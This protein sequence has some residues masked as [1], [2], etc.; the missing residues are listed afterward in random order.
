MQ[1]EKSEKYLDKYLHSM[2][3]TIG[4]SFVIG[5]RLKRKAKIS[6]WTISL[7]SLFVIIIG[8]LPLIFSLS[9]FQNKLLLA[10]SIFLSIFILILNNSEA[11]N[12]YERRSENFLIRARSLQKIYYN[13]EYL[14]NFDKINEYEFN[15]IKTEYN[16]IIKMFP[17]DPSKLDF[18]F[19]RTQN[20]RKFHS[21]KEKSKAELISEKIKYSCLYFTNLYLVPTLMLLIPIILVFIIIFNK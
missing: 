19:Y 4:V 5:N 20:H 15:R 14:I 9:D 17:E 21:S 11:G 16:D 8:I 1:I 10:V 3:I 6:N 18:Q 7:L 12:N 2:L 13:L